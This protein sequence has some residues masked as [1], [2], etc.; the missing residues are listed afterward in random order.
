MFFNLIYEPKKVYV[1]SFKDPNFKIYSIETLVTK[2]LG[3]LQHS[4]H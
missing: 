2:F 1:K 4:P 3:C